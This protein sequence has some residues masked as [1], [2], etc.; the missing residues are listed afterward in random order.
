MPVT[1]AQLQDQIKKM[2]AAAAKR[3]QEAELLKNNKIK[4]RAAQQVEEVQDAEVIVS[5]PAPKLVNKPGRVAKLKEFF[6]R[7]RHPYGNGGNFAGTYGN[8]R[9]QV[10][11]SKPEPVKSEVYNRGLAE[12]LKALQ[13]KQSTPFSKPFEKFAEAADKIQNNDTTNM[14]AGAFLYVESYS[15]QLQFSN[16]LNNFVLSE[17]RQ[18]LFV[19]MTMDENNQLRV[20]MAA[21]LQHNDMSFDKKNGLSAHSMFANAEKTFNPKPPMGTSRKLDDMEEEMLRT[22]GMRSR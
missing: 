19:G 6:D 15:L 11:S 14:K 8:N 7:V 18:A 13:P 2:Q 4:E 10:A 12:M 3:Q 5:N 16:A 17:T 9:P 22:A 20:N 1:Q 21:A